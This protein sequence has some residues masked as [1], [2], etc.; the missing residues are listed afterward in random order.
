MKN[1]LIIGNPQKV[2]QKLIE[3]QATYKADEI[4]LSTITYSAVDRINSYKLIATEL[5]I[6][7]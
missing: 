2:K 1:N 6:N 3:L 4:M 5:L 7:D